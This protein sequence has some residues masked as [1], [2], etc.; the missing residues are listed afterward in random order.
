MYSPLDI[1][2]KRSLRSLHALRTAR[3]RSLQS[4]RYLCISVLIL[5]RYI[6][7]YQLD[8]KQKR[9]LR[10]LSIAVM[11]RASLVVGVLF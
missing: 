3:Q 11:P 8:I 9:A 1:K 10:P 7:Y 4:L 5:G 2:Q 6:M